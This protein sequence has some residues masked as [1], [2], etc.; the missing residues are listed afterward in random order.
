[1]EPESKQDFEALVAAAGYEA[2][3]TTQSLQPIEALTVDLI[4][5]QIA[6]Q[7]LDFGDSRLAARLHAALV[8]G[9]HLLLQ[10]P[11]GTGK[12][13]LAIAIAKAASAAG[14]ARGHVQVAGSSDWTPADTIGTYRL[15]RSKDLEFARGLVLDA[16]HRESWMVLDELNRA[17]IDQAMG[18][19]F[20]VLSRQSVVLRFEEVDVAGDA[21]TV[22]IVPENVL[23]GANYRHYEVPA[24]WRIIATM[25]TLDID[26]LFE[27]SQAFLR[28]FA[29]I[30]VAGPA[31]PVH[32]NLL[33][34]HQ[35]GET[36]V[37]AMVLR[38]LDLPGAPLG[39]AITLDCARYVRA[40]VAAGETDAAALAGEIMESFIG[41]Q[42]THLSV[43]DQDAVRSALATVPPP[44]AAPLATPGPPAVAAPATAADAGVPPEVTGESERTTGEPGAS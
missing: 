5:S 31:R 19:L 25:N 2:A 30:N 21:Q 24:S 33:E 15:T 32:K 37:D 34:K 42:L 38:L 22:A 10:G 27:I 9:K 36:Q 1:M 39:P 4:E 44:S 6:S 11:P 18:P 12:T 7:D 29:I 17:A 8:S 23:L 41:P 35:T 43:L 26:L 16:I 40:R 13:E 20:T 14:I 3:P 28:R